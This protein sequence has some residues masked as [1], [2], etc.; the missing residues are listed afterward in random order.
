MKGREKRLGPQTPSIDRAI[1][2]EEELSLFHPHQHR[3][4]LSRALPLLSSERA[5]EGELSTCARE[6][7]EREDETRRKVLLPSLFESKSWWEKTKR[8]NEREREAK[9]RERE[10]AVF[11]LAVDDDPDRDRKRRD[12]LRVGKDKTSPWSSDGDDGESPP[13]V[14]RGSSSSARDLPALLPLPPPCSLLSLS[15]PFALASTT[16]SNTLDGL[17]RERERE[18]ETPKLAMVSFFFLTWF[19]NTQIGQSSARFF[20]KGGFKKE[21]ERRETGTRARASARK[22]K[23]QRK[24]P[25]PPRASQHKQ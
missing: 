18:R 17:Q 19:Y 8:K 14:R 2:E 25:P 9:K 10:R 16:S 11:P 7:R 4:S 12:P 13:R 6:E 3:S 24:P 5:G 20:L 23:R 1:E 21:K 22:V 15:P